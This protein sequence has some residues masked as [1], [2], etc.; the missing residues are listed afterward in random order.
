VDASR[1]TPSLVPR[2]ITE[3]TYRM[4]AASDQQA[5]ICMSIQT[6]SDEDYA[7]ALGAINA[8]EGMHA[9][10][11]SDNELAKDHLRHLM[12]GRPEDVPDERLF[13]LEFPERPGALKDFLDTLGYVCSLLRVGGWWRD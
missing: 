12:G 5:V 13:R 1:L 7:D 11:L 10:D 4:N 2:N 8:T 6:K 3:F 9:I